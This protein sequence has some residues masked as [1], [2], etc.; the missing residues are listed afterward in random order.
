MPL[1]PWVSSLAI[2]CA[3]VMLAR[4]TLAQPQAS[5]PKLTANANAQAG[6]IAPLLRITKGRF[7]AY[8]LPESHIG[9]PLESGPH[10]DLVVLPAARRSRTLVHEGLDLNTFPGTP[11][12]GRTCLD[13]YP[14]IASLGMQLTNR[15]VA[16]HRHSQWADLRRVWSDHGEAFAVENFTAFIGGRGLLLNFLEL[17]SLIHP[18]VEAEFARKQS[19]APTVTA[20]EYSVEFSAHQRLVEKVPRL[21]LESIETLEDRAWAICRLNPTQQLQ[22]LRSA[23]EH[24]DAAVARTQTRAPGSVFREVELVFAALQTQLRLMNTTASHAEA[25]R[26]GTTARL[27]SDWLKRT[28]PLA[29]GGPALDKLR[30]ELRNARWAQ[31]MDEHA[32]ARRT[33][34][35][36]VLGASHLLDFEH[37][38]GLLTL[39]KRR[40]FR[41]EVVQ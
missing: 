8:L 39:L 7:S 16:N 30:F 21:K 26:S 37:F 14:E 13:D 1:S 38:D 25:L 27:S 41:V 2:A 29:S 31:R 36:Y 18:S 3:S 34:L 35:M 40:G 5:R 19:D 33:G 10:F 23:I 32:Q 12:W 11:Y 28:Y 6:P 4:E 15:I 20:R 17:R 22:A 24:F 9:S